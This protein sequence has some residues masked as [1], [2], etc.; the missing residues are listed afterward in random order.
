MQKKLYFCPT[1]EAK[2]SN[3]AQAAKESDNWAEL[4]IF[5]SFQIWSR[6]LSQ[7]APSYFV[8][9]LKTGKRLGNLA[10]FG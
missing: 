4:T 5:S 7:P 3:L 1:S 9:H 6:I 2:Q 8:L 10:N